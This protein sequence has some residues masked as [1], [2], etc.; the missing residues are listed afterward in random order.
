[1]I[2][3]PEAEIAKARDEAVREHGQLEGPIGVHPANRE[4]LKL[5]LA[6]S[7]QWRVG[8][9]STMAQA[10]V[11]K[12]GLDYGALRDT[13]DLAGLAPIAPETF[14]RL[15]MMESQALAAWAEARK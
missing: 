3:M 13:A 10:Q 5:L 8:S 9:L 2:G 15:R 11:I 6:M 1:M 4:P 12:V 14:T 7:T